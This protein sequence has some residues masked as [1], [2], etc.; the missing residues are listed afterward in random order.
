LSVDEMPDDMLPPGAVVGDLRVVMEPCVTKADNSSYRHSERK[1]YVDVSGATIVRALGG[2]WHGKSGKT[3]CPA[4][5]D[6]NASL[7]VAEKD[8]KTLVWCG[9]GCS[10]DQVLAALIDLGLWHNS[11][12]SRTSRCAAWSPSWPNAA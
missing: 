8:G 7:E 9:A 4:H 1:A 3:Y 12:A 5:D 11:D 6:D 2:K 10:Q